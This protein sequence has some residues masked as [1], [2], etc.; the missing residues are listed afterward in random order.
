MKLI[1]ERIVLLVA[2]LVVAARSG[3]VN[4]TTIENRIN[5]G[6]GITGFLSKLR[7]NVETGAQQVKETVREGYNFVKQKLSMTNNE[8]AETIVSNKTNE[9]SEN[10]KV[11]ENIETTEHVENNRNDVNIK[12]KND[13]ES[14]NEEQGDGG[15]IN[16]DR[17]I[18][19]DDDNKSLDYRNAFPTLNVSGV[20][21]RPILLETSNK[22]GNVSIGDRNALTA[23]KICPSGHRLV[24]DKCV[25]IINMDF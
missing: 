14:E 19:E 11:E 23:P 20:L 15:I 1:N 7:Q 25:A 8:T 3:T 17:I 6:S 22:T 18:F 5:I 2:V 24:D 16:N 12:D 10:T 9:I 13:A 21:T 4:E